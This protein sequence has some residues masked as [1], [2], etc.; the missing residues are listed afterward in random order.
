MIGERFR[1]ALVASA[2]LLWVFLL[3]TA[4][5]PAHVVEEWD[6]HLLADGKEK[7]HIH[8]CVV[9]ELRPGMEDAFPRGEAA[10]WKKWAKEAFDNWQKALSK[11]KKK[12]T[13][14]EVDFWSGEPKCQIQ[15]RWSTT[16]RS[17]YGRASV[18]DYKKGEHRAETVQIYVH[19]VDA[20]KRPRK[21]GRKGDDT[22]DPVRLLMHEI[23]HAIRLD[24]TENPKDIMSSGVEDDAKEK[25]NHN[26]KLSEEDIKE[27]GD[28]AA[29]KLKVAM[30]PA[31]PDAAALPTGPVVNAY[32][33]M[34][35][36]AHDRY[37][38]LDAAHDWLERALELD[39]YN[40]TARAMLERVEAAEQQVGLQRM[41]VALG[42]L[43]QMLIRRQL[44]EQRRQ[45]E[46]EELHEGEHHPHEEVH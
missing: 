26:T 41:G 36:D 9:F 38:D 31:E 6:W 14:E 21:F 35:A 44:E 29:G 23:G 39:P 13:F 11:R 45:E 33:F 24:D 17:D 2:V 20:K 25:G 46:W 43:Q 42:T 37:Q 1:L 4:P 8:W 15:I 18:P 19:G 16:P 30:L 5:A 40:T 28:A 3:R 10:K 7:R 27:A 32:M 34:A 22:Y 12:W